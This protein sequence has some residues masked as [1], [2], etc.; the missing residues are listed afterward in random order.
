MP[1]QISLM[2][3][4][5]YHSAGLITGISSE[6][7]KAGKKGKREKGKNREKGTLPGRLTHFLHCKAVKC[8]VL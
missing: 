4:N 8:N 6:K 7:R 3:G 1:I 2:K 5:L